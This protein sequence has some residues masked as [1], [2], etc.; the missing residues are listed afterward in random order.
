MNNGINAWINAAYPTL[1][2]YTALEDLYATKQFE[3]FP[4]PASNF[5]NVNMESEGA[6]KLFLIDLTGK[7]IREEFL[8]PGLQYI[9][10]SEIPKGLYIIKVQSDKVVYSEKITIL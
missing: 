8:E 9:D 1:T 6:G 7:V 3:L 10:I 5:L 4:N 2:C